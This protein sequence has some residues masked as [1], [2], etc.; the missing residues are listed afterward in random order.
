[1]LIRDG[2]HGVALLR[3]LAKHVS[4]QREYLRQRVL[5]PVRRSRPRSRVSSRVE[6]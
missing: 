2:H 5:G 4:Q 1:M 3:R 6:Y